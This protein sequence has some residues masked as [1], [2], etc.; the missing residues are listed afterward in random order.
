MA[1]IKMLHTEEKN[2]LVYAFSYGYVDREQELQWVEH[3]VTAK[4]TGDK[5]T[6]N[7]AK[8]DNQN[9]DQFQSYIAL[10]AKVNQVV[11]TN[12]TNLFGITVEKP[13]PVAVA[14][15]E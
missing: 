8:V 14:T 15:K 3:V 4:R 5:W 10:L 13:K 6:F 9:A 2:A 7:F 11:E 1:N 12:A